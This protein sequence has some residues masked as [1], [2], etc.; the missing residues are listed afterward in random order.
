MKR[1]IVP[2]I[3]FTLVC[4]T[5]M[6]A[7]RE[8]EMKGRQLISQKPSFSM[9]L[10]AELRLIHSF[11]VEHPDESSMTRAYFFIKE[12]AK[13][14]EQMVIVQIADKTNPMAG[15][16]TVPPLKSDTDKRLYLKS[17]QKKG[18]VDVDYLIQLI[19]WNPEASSLQPIS[20]KGV[21]VPSH[22]ALQGQ[23]LFGYGGEHAILIRYSRDVN[24]FGMRVS[25]RA[26]AHAWNKESMSGNAKKVYETFREEF[27]GVVDSLTVKGP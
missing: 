27:T 24:S 4:T 17:S 25:G 21:I 9:N 12:K 2:A 18:R 13:Q 11:T 16:M 5:V 23:L 20:K 6:A 15:P 8:I 7:E 19:V 10:P 14:V 3:I 1:G 26:D 22:L